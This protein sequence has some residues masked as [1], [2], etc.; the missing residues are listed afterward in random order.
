V[1]KLMLIVV[2]YHYVRPRF[3][4][5][6]AGIHGVTVS[7]LQAQLQLLGTLGEFVTASQVREAVRGGSPLPRRALL[8]TFDD[9]LREQVDHALPVLDGLGIPAVFFV[10]TGP[11]ANDAVSTVHKIHLLRAHLPPAE[12][13][14]LV[15]AQ[16]RSEGIE[17]SLAD[18]AQAAS[19]YPW[20]APEDA[21]LKHL[22]N[23]QLP[24]GVADALVARCFRLVF[25][26]DEPAASRALYMDMEQLRM[27]GARGY[28]GSHG[29]RH[30]PLGR[31]P[32]AAAHENVRTSL[33]LLAGWTGVRPFAL[34]YPYGSLHA[35][36]LEAGDAAAAAG[37]QVAFT[38]ERA[39]NVDLRRPLHLARFDCN[40]L[41]GGR[42]PCFVGE[43]LFESAPR[44]QWYR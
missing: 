3:A 6:F 13:A 2:T 8:V 11:I 32:W 42:Q 5:G 30:L 29:D 27:L 44:A 19:S 36:T 25:G 34:S 9:G 43:S 35:S 4:H 39:A 21:Q 17:E 14:A 10:N 31:L 38:M 18:P 23:H 20:D 41:P 1:E 12:F 24:P 33:D 37:V 22:L 40:D 26:Q 16:A 7:A 15:Y 28:L